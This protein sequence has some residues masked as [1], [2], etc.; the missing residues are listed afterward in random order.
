MLKDHGYR[1]YQVNPSAQIIE[2]DRCYPRLRD[3]PEIVGGIVIV[4][5]PKQTEKVVKEAAE[6]GIQRVWM[7]QGSESTKAIEYCE[8]YGLYAVYGRCIC[9]FAE[10]VTSFHKV[11]RWTQKMLQRLPQ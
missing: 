7:Q 6:T 3:L 9:M 10:P 8:Q 1:V 4:V 5:P 11:H 2:G